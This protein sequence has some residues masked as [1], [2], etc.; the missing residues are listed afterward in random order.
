M[1]FPA[2][3]PSAAR[4]AARANHPILSNWLKLTTSSDRH[5]HCERSEAIHH[6]F[7]IMDCFVALRAPRNDGSEQAKT[8]EL[9]LILS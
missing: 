8:I 9:D 6:Q 2:M 7:Q 5:G 1:S 4:I 3:I